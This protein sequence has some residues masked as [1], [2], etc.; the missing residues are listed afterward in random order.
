M[1]WAADLGIDEWLNLWDEPDGG[2]CLDYI[3]G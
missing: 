1:D 2:S 3:G